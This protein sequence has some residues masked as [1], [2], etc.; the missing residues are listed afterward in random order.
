V[1]I[2]AIILDVGGVILHEKDHAK[3]FVW[4]SRLGLPQGELTRLVLDSE[5]AARAASGQVAEREVMW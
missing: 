1:P 3:R 2:R 4:E 5:P